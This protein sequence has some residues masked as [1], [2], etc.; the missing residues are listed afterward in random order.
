LRRGV[1]LRS[2]L[3]ALVAFKDRGAEVALAVL[4]H[5]PLQF[6]NA[7]DQAARVVAA[8]V[9]QTGAGPLA[10]GGVEAFFHLE[11]EDFLDD[12]LDERAQN[13]VVLFTSSRLM[14]DF[15]LV[16]DL[17]L[18]DCVCSGFQENHNDTLVC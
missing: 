15:F 2:A 16:M 7:R 13:V 5:A 8:A 12:P 18:L 1:S 9:A 17:V 10:P 3:A 4:G 6:A 11:F 14:I